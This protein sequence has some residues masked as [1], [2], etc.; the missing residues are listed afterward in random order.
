[1]GEVYKAQD[2]RL[3]RTIAIK[4]LPA[5][6]ADKGEVRERFERE[7]K[8]IASLNHPHISVLHDI[9][10]QDGIDFLVMEYLE[11]ETLATRLLKGPLPLEQVLR[12]AIEIA[13]ALDKAHRK[14]ITHRDLKPGNIMLTK[15]G[16]K[17][18]DFGLAKL[19]EAAPASTP[20]SQ[21]PTLSHNPTAE[22]TILG[23]LQYMA[24]EQLEGKNDEI[25]GRTDIFAFGAV[26]YEMATGKRAFEGK[27]SASL[28]A[29]ILETDPPPISTLQ[30]T[31]PPALD[32]VVKTCLA[33]TPDERWQAA[34][35][36]C[37]ELKWIAEG[38]SQATSLPPAPAKGIRMLGRQP[39]LYGLST[40]LLGAVVAGIAAWTLKPAPPVARAVSRFEY[41]LPQSHR[42]R[43]TGR[44]VMALSP[45]GS[46]FVYNTSQGLYL[47]SMDQLEARLIPGTEA[48]LTNPFFSPDGQW[49]GFWQDN[50]LKKIAISGGA[51][52]PIC[53]AS[54]LFGASWAPDNSIFFAQPEGIW[55]ISANSGTPE[56]IIPSQ[57]QA[58]EQFDGPQLLPGG[59]WVMFAV[60]GG[61]ASWD[62]ARIV[63]QSLKTKERRDIW[64]GGSD[65]RYIP[66]GHIVYA[67]GTN[68]FAVPFDLATLSVRGSPVQVAEGVLRAKG[69]TA[70][71]NYG[72][73]DGT[74]SL[75]HFAGHSATQ[76]VSI[77]WMDREGKFTPL[78]KAPGNYYDLVFSPDGKRLAMDI[79]D[80]AKTDIWV[81]ELERDILTRLTFGGT[82]HFPFW[83][84]DAKR[85]VYS[86]QDKGGPLNLWWIRA[87]G[88]GA[89]ERLAKSNGAQLWAAWRPDGKVMAFEQANP[90]TND[91]VMTL[92]M[93]GDE[94]SGWKPGD[95]APFV[96]S[97]FYEGE[98]AF[99]PDGRWLAHPSNE[100]GRFEVY[101]RPFPGP[102]SK[103]QI[104]TGG[105]VN[106]EWSPNG[107]ELF[108][109][110]V[111]GKIMVVTYRVSGDSF[112][113][114]APQL[115]SSGQLTS[116]RD[117]HNFTL[118][119]DGKR[120]AVLTALDTEKTPEANKINIV[121][122]WLEDLKR[123]V[124]TGAK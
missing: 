116:I 85:I 84:P 33:K 104:S 38:G 23:T 99:S 102:G 114:E 11:G 53:A 25:D 48:A 45:D 65:A 42:L 120:F 29:K 67:L 89:P 59:E 86:S 91:D 15:N 81:Y 27:T 60:G 49:I 28:I 8:T 98:P 100:S 5:H 63:V 24:P 93:E 78:R 20:M 3:E 124:P 16:T 31:T 47:R 35:D 94:K 1:M 64:Q 88:G 62:D 77:S 76:A 71:A 55:W 75:V 46:R 61:F 83:T 92:S 19:K 50:Q 112:H 82:N 80:G 54:N 26:V 107:K 68:L 101:V 119:P 39:L 51:A 4:V 121:L 34:G 41:D 69:E 74:G 36:L 56:L 108:Y 95:P 58:G 97:G 87:D 10:H 7:A 106:P 22:G 79:G 122:N 105:G 32:R 109:K 123:R 9:G 30:P 115:W 72:I 44:A 110:T 21:L 6:L 113:A 70:S 43:N 14:G 117:S 90:E 118:H 13:D 73:S 66:T 40:L 57:A 103:W 111:D 12:Y 96:N 52:V 18:L 2:T 17:L 37:R